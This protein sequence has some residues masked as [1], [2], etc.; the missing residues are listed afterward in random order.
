MHKNTCTRTHARMHPGRADLLAE[1]QQVTAQV[2]D[3]A[4]RTENHGRTQADLMG[5][6]GEGSVC[7]CRDAP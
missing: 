7:V 1:L 3:V 6:R 4:A 5:E 2:D